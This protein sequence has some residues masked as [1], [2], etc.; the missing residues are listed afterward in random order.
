MPLTPVIPP[1]V[2]IGGAVVVRVDDG[3]IGGRPDGH[4]LLGE[5]AKEHAAGVGFAAIEAEGEFVEVVVEMLVLDSDPEG[6]H[7]PSPSC[8]PDPFAMHPCIR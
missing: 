5:T 8:R 4:G 6:S 3:A 2:A 1:W 7:E